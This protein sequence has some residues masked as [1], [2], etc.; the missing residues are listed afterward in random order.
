MAILVI[1]LIVIAFFAIILA[2]LYNRLVALRNRVKN[3]WSQISVQL[4]RRHDLIPNLVEAVKGYMKY[5]QET[6]TKVIAA[7]S[8][9]VSAR[10][11]KET[12]KAEG[13]LGATLGHLLALF[14]KYPELKA[15]E[16]VMRLQEELTTTENQIAFARQFYNDS[17]MKLNNSLEQFPTN[18]IAGMFNFQ[19]REFFE[20][21]PE[22][23]E[24]P[25]VDLSF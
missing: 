6:L 14:E 25:K 10:G 7:R 13:E 1:V 23:K 5:E 9:A 17:V 3:A 16:N 19:H 4:K 11:V 2:V 20:A 24:P 12:A 22:V 18:I 21:P 15:N 8:K